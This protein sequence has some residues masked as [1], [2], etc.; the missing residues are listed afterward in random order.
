MPRRLGAGI[1]AQNIDRT[2]LLV[3][4]ELETQRAY[5]REGDRHGGRSL[6]TAAELARHRPTLGLDGLDDLLVRHAG[7]GCAAHGHQLQARAQLR[8]LLRLRAG[9]DTQH[10]DRARRLVR[11]EL[12][13]QRAGL[14]EGDGNVGAWRCRLGGLSRRRGLRGGCAAAAELARQRPALALDSLDHLLVRHASHRCAA[15][16]QQHQPR[17]QLGVLL[18]LGAGVDCQDLHSTGR[19]VLREL[20]A[21]RASVCELHGHVCALSASFFLRLFSL[22]ALFERSQS[23]LLLCCCDRR[24]CQGTLAVLKHRHAAQVHL[25]LALDPVP[26]FGLAHPGRALGARGSFAPEG[27]EEGEH[28][29]SLPQRRHLPARE[30]FAVRLCSLAASIAEQLHDVV[31]PVLA[32]VQ[33]RAHAAVIGPV[34]VLTS[35]TD[36][37]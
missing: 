30:A 5:L 32:R 6:S 9:I 29:L 15:H 3:L 12:E 4:R 27:I 11:C 35:P 14:R 36:Q 10:L 24:L 33:V 34:N 26:A 23:I 28:V 8:V 19:L 31:V 37:D 17:P 7:N 18:R 16:L 20:E 22:L 1:N 2:G 25:R 21:K 13:T